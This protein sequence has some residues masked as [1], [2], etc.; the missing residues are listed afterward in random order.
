MRAR[1]TGT[2]DSENASSAGKK[3]SDVENGSG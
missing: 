1:V 2:H 3:S